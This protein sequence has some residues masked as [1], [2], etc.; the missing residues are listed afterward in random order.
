MALLRKMTCNLRHPMGLRHPVSCSSTGWRGLIGSPKLQINFH[1]RA[2]KYRSLLR[3]ITYNDKGPYQSSPPCILTMSL[4]PH[5]HLPLPLPPPLKHTHTYTRAHTLSHT[6]SHTHTQFWPGE[7]VN[8]RSREH[9][10]GLS[11]S[12]SPSH[13]LTR[14]CTLSLFVSLALCLLSYG[15]T[16]L[17]LAL[18]LCPPRCFYPNLSLSLSRSITH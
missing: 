17:S 3:K 16:F 12:L 8:T 2:T 15:V 11:F 18:S 7:R 5:P 6:H 1:K 4:Q 10:L 14:T 13:S 9:T